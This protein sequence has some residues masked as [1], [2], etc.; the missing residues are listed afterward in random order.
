D[1]YLLSGVSGHGARSFYYPPKAVPNC[2]GCHMPLQ[3]SQDFGA[4]FFNP[5]ND[6]TRYIHN[7]LFPGANTGLAFIRGDTNVVNAETAFLKGSLRVD[8]FGIKDGG[9]I[10]NSLTAPLRPNVPALK[11]GHH[12]LLEVVLRTMKVGHLFTQGTVDSNEV[13]VDSKV[14]SGDK[15]I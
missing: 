10:D 15:V 5:T 8:I 1:P 12:Y 13:W 7:H 3:E 2:A 11:R 9:S 4:N 14:N 6:S